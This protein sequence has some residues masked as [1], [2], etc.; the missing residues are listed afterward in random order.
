VNRLQKAI[1][2]FR[3]RRIRKHIDTAVELTQTGYGLIAMLTSNKQLLDAAYD[4][5]N[6]SVDRLM[7]LMSELSVIQYEVRHNLPY[8]EVSTRL[9]SISKQI[10]P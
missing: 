4:E 10:N 1:I 5:T 7:N 9:T 8:R 6:K 2:S 3:I